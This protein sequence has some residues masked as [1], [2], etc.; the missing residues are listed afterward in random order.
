M[1]DAKQKTG[2][3]CRKSVGSLNKSALYF[4]PYFLPTKV[5]IARTAGTEAKLMIKNIKGYFCGDC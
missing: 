2:S 5:D 4:R 1:K 3:A